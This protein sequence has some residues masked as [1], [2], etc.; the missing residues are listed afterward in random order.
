MKKL[1]NAQCFRLRSLL[2]RLLVH[3]LERGVI[4]LG[5]YKLHVVDVEDDWQVKPGDI[6]IQKQ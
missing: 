1:T 6:V 2:G 4:D 5:D 3:L